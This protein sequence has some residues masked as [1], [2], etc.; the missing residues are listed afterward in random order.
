MEFYMRPEAEMGKVAP[1]PPIQPKEKD[2]RMKRWKLGRSKREFTI[3]YFISIFI[4]TYIG[5]IIIYGNNNYCSHM[6]ERKRERER[7][8]SNNRETT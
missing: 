8:S 2:W 3:V 1:E 6:R 4:T 5:A 7:G